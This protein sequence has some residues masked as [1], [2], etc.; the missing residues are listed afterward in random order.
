MRRL[1]EHGCVCVVAWPAKY[2]MAEHAVSNLSIR[3]F[4]MCPPP[5]PPVSKMDAKFGARH[6]VSTLQTPRRAK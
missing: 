5:P 3:Q 2:V 1:C 4:T 6:P